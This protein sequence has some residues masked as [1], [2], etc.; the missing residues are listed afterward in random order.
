MDWFEKVGL[1]DAIDQIVG[2]T[3]LLYLCSSFTGENT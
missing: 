3:V 2:L 1:L